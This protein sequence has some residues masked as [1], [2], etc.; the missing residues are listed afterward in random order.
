MK[1]LTKSILATALIISASSAIAA[2]GYSIAKIKEMVCNMDDNTDKKI[3]FKEFFE[4][5]VT[6]NNDSYDVNKDGYITA[7]EVALEM[8]ED[9]VDTINELRK[10]GVSEENTN[11]TIESELNAI[12]SESAAII[13]TMDTDGDNLVEPEEIKAFQKQKF[14]ELDKNKDNLISKKDLTSKKHQLYTYKKYQK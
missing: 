14:A 4:A 6:D 2:E 12:E 10:H 13:A 7:G 5:N 1:N 8:K 9:L 11:A 3:N